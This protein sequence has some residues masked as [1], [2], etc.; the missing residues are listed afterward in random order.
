MLGALFTHG[1]TIGFSGNAAA[2][3]WP[4]ALVVLAASSFVLIRRRRELPVVGSQL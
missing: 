2:E 3:M 4:L 1:T